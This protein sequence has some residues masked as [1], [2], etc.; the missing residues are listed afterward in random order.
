M[1]LGPFDVR[2]Q[3]ALQNRLQKTLQF[4]RLPARLHFDPAVGQ[5][6]HPTRHF[7][8]AGQ[9]PHAVPETH[10]LHPSFIKHLDPSHSLFY[11]SQPALR[12]R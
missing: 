12:A 10:S 11:S 8:A 5:I 3:F 1:A 9:L 7:E 2:F 4:R 6:P